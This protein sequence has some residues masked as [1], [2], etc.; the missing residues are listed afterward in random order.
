[1]CGFVGFVSEIDNK[2]IV[3]KK[4]SD[5]IVHRGPDSEGFFID[6]SVAFGFRRLS[7]VDTSSAGHQ[8]MYS[9]DKNKC[10]VF[11]GEVYGYREL[12]KSIDNYCNPL[13]HNIV[14]TN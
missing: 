8:P 11:N 6:D 9:Q 7:I 2:D 5:R 3:I 12:K 10:I 14:W 4:M 1:M 13:Y